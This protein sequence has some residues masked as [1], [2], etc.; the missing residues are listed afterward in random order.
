[1]FYILVKQTRGLLMTIQ[2]LCVRGSPFSS[3]RP[4]PSFNCVGLIL[5]AVLIQAFSLL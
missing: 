2:A 5:E 3:H 1:M 4:Q